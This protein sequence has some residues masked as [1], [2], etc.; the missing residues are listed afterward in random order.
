M[1]SKVRNNQ[2]EKKHPG[3]NVFDRALLK[4][5]M[6]HFHMRK[7]KLLNVNLLRKLTVNTSSIKR[8]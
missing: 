3:Q 8:Q 7:I 6:I 4:Q 2:I 1:G 5:R